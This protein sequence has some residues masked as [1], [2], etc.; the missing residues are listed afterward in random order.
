MRASGYPPSYYKKYIYPRRYYMATVETDN[1][2]V[3][4]RP[5]AGKDKGIARNNAK[6]RFDTI[7]VISVEEITYDKYRLL[8]EKTPQHKNA[9]KRVRHDTQTTSN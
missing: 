8:V 3:V 6:N 2:E 1:G 4:V 7:T 5:Y 9:N